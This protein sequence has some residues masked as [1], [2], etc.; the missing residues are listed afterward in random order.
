MKFTNAKNFIFENNVLYD[1]MRSHIRAVQIR[2]AKIR[3]NIMIRSQKDPISQE[4]ASVCLENKQMLNTPYEDN[5]SITSNECYGSEDIGFVLPY[6]P[7]GKY[8]DLVTGNVAGGCLVGFFMV[9][10]EKETSKCV[11]CADIKAFN[12]KYGVLGNPDQVTTLIYNKLILT[13][14]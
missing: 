7:C 5:V 13:G 10:L 4:N 2:Q 9:K 14:N 1:S 6:M 12:C 3:S 8:Q 11:T